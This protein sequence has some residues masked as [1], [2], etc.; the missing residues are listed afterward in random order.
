MVPGIVLILLGLSVALAVT[1][2][3]SQNQDVHNKIGLDQ[4]LGNKLPLDAAFR[5]EH[6]QKVKLGDFFGKR[7][8]VLMLVFYTCQGA[9]QLELENA[10]KSFS[11]MKIQDIGRDYE[12]VSIS[13]HPK[14]T[15]ALAAAKKADVLRGYGRTGGYDGWHFLTGDYDQIKRV[16]DAVGFKYSYDAVK[17]Q[18]LH[19]TGLFVLT[20]DGRLSRY[21]YGVDYTSPLLADSLKTAGE[22]QIN[23]PSEPIL[24]GCFQYDEKTGK[25]RLN[26]LRALQVGGIGSVIILAVSIFFMSRKVGNQKPGGG[27]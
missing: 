19:P 8:V 3:R 25:T 10:T 2:K 1:L 5:D 9:C 20:P 22:G 7:P 13:I 12:V 27:A 23:V 17:D 26:V 21:L 4:R 6:N 16:T 11:D 14:E 18:I 24:F 15:P